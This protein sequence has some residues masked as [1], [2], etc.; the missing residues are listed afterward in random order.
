MLVSEFDYD[1][2]E[3]LIAQ[4]P[5]SPRDHSRL[6]VL[7]RDT[8]TWEH[9]HF[10]DLPSYLAPGDV[11]VLNETRV[12]PAR[13]L[14]KRAGTGGR[15][16]LLLVHPL[17]DGRWEGLV[18]PSRRLRTGDRLEFGDGRLVAQV[19]D[20]CGE[21]RRVVSLTADGKDVM[22]AI[23]AIGRVPVPP[24]IK[25]PLHDPGRYQTV[26]ARNTGSV[27]APTAGLHFTPE[28]LQS[29]AQKGVHEVYITLHVGIGTFRPVRVENVEEHVMDEEFYEIPA[30]AA[31]EINHARSQGG[32][33]VAVGTT[34]C[35]TLES[36]VGADGLLQCQ[37][38]STDLFIRPGHQWRAVDALITNFHLPRSTLLMLVSSFAG[39]EFVMAAYREA[40]EQRYR[41]YSFGD[42]MLIL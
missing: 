5:L 12:F 42:A 18:R 11:L 20:D 27:A 9:R 30:K 37:S 25:K 23:E 6:M 26:Y 38:T 33:V 15:V 3:E 31:A 34:V 36:A 7:H 32:R 22:A 24:Y 21:G 4:E 39:R 2:P 41:F 29:I 16:E 17:P 14:G 8:K 28:L 13:L 35:R 10:Y 1:L 40:I 19:E